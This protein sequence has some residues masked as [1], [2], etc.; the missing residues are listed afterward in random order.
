MFFAFLGAGERSPVSAHISRRLPLLAHGLVALLA[1]ASVWSVDY[2]PT[3]DGP[4]HIFGVHASQRLDEPATG[5]GRFLEPNL[6]IT[7]HGFALVFAPFDLW[8][9][10]RTATRLALSCLVL[11]WCAGA[12]FLVRAVQPRR[13]WIGVALA[14]AAFQW[15]L[16]MGLFSF[17]LASA[18]G[19]CVLA[20][21]LAPQPW[22]RARGAALAALL[23]AQVLMHAVPAAITGAL[24]LLLALLRSRPGERGRALCRV[25]LLGAPATCVALTLVAAGFE[26]L[27]RD[28]NGSLGIWSPAQTP[29]WA[30]AGCFTGGPGWRA[31]FL[32]LLALSAPLA[33][34]WLRRSD[35]VRSAD[36][37]LLAGGAALLALGLAAPLHLRAW[38]YF[39]VRFL[40]AAICCLAVA[41]PVERL[42]SGALRGLAAAL[43]ATWAF[44]SS[45]WA[46][47]YNRELAGRA[48]DALAG[49]DAD[50]VRDGPRLPIVL[51]PYLG[52]P[53]D[54]RRAPMPYVVPLA[55]LGQ[56]YAAA[57]GGYAPHSFALSWQI[58]PVLLR[59]E[60]RRAFPPTVDRSYARDL[61]KPALAGD[62]ELREAIATYLGA[63]GSHYQDVILWGRP[64]DV[65]HLIRLGYEP[66]FR[67][68]GLLLARFRGCPLTL[69]FPPASSPPPGTLVELGW[70]PA[71]HVTHRY[72]ADKSTSD[73][74]GRRVMPLA[75]PPCGGV[76]IR[77]AAEAEAIECE[78]AD[79]QGRLLIAS[80]RA[81]PRVECRV[82]PRKDRT[83]RA[84]VG[85]DGAGAEPRGSG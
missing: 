55:N 65:D 70:L 80:T 18:F 31:W 54:E 25:A 41:W 13:A 8:L 76:W 6:P 51:D 2:L 24:V 5:Y 69:I 37:A 19:L 59:E 28:A 43:L 23:L 81:A 74:G 10:W 77:L 11:V 7:S 15:S 49:L 32:P 30:V 29:L 17:Y 83:A 68:G 66:D 48:A 63:V 35:A 22:S 53:F 46:L 58:H 16:Y 34:W 38:D 12:F 39:S 84:G 82:R 52:R 67:R 26:S 72:S 78:G 60:A 73:A 9:P 61:A 1:L 42:R 36:V 33:V 21:A 85:S 20:A 56:L 4:Q 50:V 27:A 79:A 3:H 71:W 47:A 75:T 64:E 40:P 57:Q 62:R 45:G 44:A 14:A